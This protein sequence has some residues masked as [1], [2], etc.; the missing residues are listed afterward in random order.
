M[1]ESTKQR[2]LEWKRELEERD[3]M[4]RGELKESDATY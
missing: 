2:D 1:E 4:W 3:Q